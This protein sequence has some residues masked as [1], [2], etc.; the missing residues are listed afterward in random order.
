MLLQMGTKGVNLAILCICAFFEVHQEDEMV[1]NL[2][3]VKK[4]IS[5]K[6]CLNPLKREQKRVMVAQHVV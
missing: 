5:L 6:F 2:I 1:K 4:L 3:T